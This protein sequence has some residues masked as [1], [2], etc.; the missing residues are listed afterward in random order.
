MDELRE[1][2]REIANAGGVRLLGLFMRLLG[3]MR[4]NMMLM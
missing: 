3:I 1:K 4:M 2:I